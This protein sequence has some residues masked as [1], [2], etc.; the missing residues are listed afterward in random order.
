[1]LSAAGEDVKGAKKTRKETY[2]M[3]SCLEGDG[4]TP[5][6]RRRF[7]RKT[8]EGNQTKDYRHRETA[9]RASFRPKSM[10]FSSPPPHRP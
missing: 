10:A 8:Q 4:R 5:S 2:Q 7:I 9:V 3:H 6:R 1:M